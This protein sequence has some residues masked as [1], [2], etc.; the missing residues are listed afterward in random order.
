MID[1]NV[2]MR[3]WDS[4]ALVLLIVEQPLSVSARHLLKADAEIAVWW[5]SRVECV[6]AIRRLH[7]DGILTHKV[8]SGAVAR[9]L[10]LFSGCYE[11]AP[12]DRLRERAERL[13]NIH[14]LSAADSLQLAAALMVTQEQPTGCEVVCHDLRLR[15]AAQREGFTVLPD[16]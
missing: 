14:P 6:S 8:A 10:L 12:S 3:F 9:A 16:L 5:G 1:E 2:A 11:V 13:L 4:S 7:R 15:L